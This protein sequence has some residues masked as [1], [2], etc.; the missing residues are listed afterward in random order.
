M[1]PLQYDLLQPNVIAT[2]WQDTNLSQQLQQML[3]YFLT[4]R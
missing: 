2:V 4:M 3:N 1:I